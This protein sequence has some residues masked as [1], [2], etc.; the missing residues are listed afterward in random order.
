MCTHSHGG[1]KVTGVKHL[2]VRSTVLVFK[3]SAPK[4][5]S[6]MSP[7]DPSIVKRL[8]G[9]LLRESVSFSGIPCRGMKSVVNRKHFTK[10]HT[11]IHCDKKLMHT[12]PKHT[13]KMY[14]HTRLHTHHASVEIFVVL[15]SMALTH[16]IHSSASRVLLSVESAA[17][18]IS[19]GIERSFTF[20]NL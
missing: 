19:S 18:R 11:G 7:T 8:R 2:T 5:G 15:C 10:S 20:V 6:S 17:P 12:C 14:V 4:M 13:V 1:F 9:V 3:A 16:C